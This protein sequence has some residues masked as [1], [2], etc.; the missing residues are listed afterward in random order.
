MTANGT[1]GSSTSY[2]GAGGRIAVRLTG[3]GATFDEFGVLKINAKGGT[4]S[5]GTASLM[6]SAGTVYLQTGAQAERAGTLI[7]RNTGDAANTAVTPIP[8][9]RW[10]GENDVLDAASLSIEAAACVKLTK[11]FKMGGATVASGSSIDLNGY[12]LTLKGM[13]IGTVRIAPGTYSASYFVSGVTDSSAGATGA[14]TVLG[15]PSLISIR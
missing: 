8:S 13:T 7:V 12:T 4:H 15:E 5:S 11:S 2:S 1:A 10:G 9:T 14:L 3:M 6:A